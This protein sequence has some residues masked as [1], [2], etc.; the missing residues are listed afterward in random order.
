MRSVLYFIEVRY[1]LFVNINL[2]NSNCWPEK[3]RIMNAEVLLH[4]SPQWSVELTYRM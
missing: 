1:I 3:S 2:K 4:W